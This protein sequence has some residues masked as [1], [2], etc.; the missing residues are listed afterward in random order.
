MHLLHGLRRR[1][2]RT[3]GFIGG[4]VPLPLYQARPDIRAI[5]HIQSCWATAMACSENI[6][7]KPDFI[8]EIPVYVKKIG[9]IPFILPGSAELA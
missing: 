4:I 1:C 8:P 2:R 5:L 9:S 3:A 7:F 6:A